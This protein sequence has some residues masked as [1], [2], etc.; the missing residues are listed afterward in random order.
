[1]LIFFLHL[2]YMLG[3]FALLF[4][5][6]FSFKYMRV[7]GLSLRGKKNCVMCLD[8]CLVCQ[9][10]FK[11]PLP[12]IAFFFFCRFSWILD[13]TLSERISFFL[14]KKKCIYIFNSA[15]HVF[16]YSWCCISCMGHYF[17]LFYCWLLCLII[18]LKLCH[19]VT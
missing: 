2:I 10:L 11:L 15:Y 9:F 5:C 18:L 1:L 3:Y 14:K 17:G 12:F 8:D 4:D 13:N 16:Y 7:L 6:L 19:F